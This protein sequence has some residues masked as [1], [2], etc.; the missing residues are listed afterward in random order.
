MLLLGNRLARLCLTAHHAFS[1]PLMAWQTWYVY[2]YFLKEQLIPRGLGGHGITNVIITV[3]LASSYKRN[4]YILCQDCVT[5]VLTTSA[6]LASGRMEAEV[7]YSFRV[8]M[9][10]EV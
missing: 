4:W 2:V 10:K 3:V 6:C 9:D 5:R 8:D 1:C 7:L